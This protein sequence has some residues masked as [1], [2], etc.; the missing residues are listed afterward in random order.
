MAPGRTSRLRVTLSIL[1]VTIVGIYFGF[2]PDFGD[3]GDKTDLTQILSF[4]PIRHARRCCGVC[5]VHPEL[6]EESG[7]RISS[8]GR[9]VL[10]RY[11][12]ARMAR[13]MSYMGEPRHATPFLISLG[14]GD[15]VRRFIIKAK[16]VQGFNAGVIGG[17]GGHP[18][19]SHWLNGSIH[20][21]YGSHREWLL[22]N[23]L[24][25]T[26]PQDVDLVI[27][28]Q[29]ELRRFSHGLM[30]ISAINDHRWVATPSTAYA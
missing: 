29:G 13:A 9:A 30:Q 17:S 21:L 5:D 16:Q 18:A 14:S 12:E 15:R 10:R 19:I 20:W 2:S 26:I 3:L 4:N 7:W 1:F 24:Q 11:R 23:V 27:E 22:F 6:C 28:D 8:W 25:R